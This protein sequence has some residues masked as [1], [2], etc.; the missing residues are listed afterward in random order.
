MGYP[1]ITTEVQETPGKDSFD[2]EERRIVCAAL[3]SFR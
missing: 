3:D 2:D 1:K